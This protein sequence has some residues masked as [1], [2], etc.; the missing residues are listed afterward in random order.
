MKE[1]RCPKCAGLMVAGRVCDNTVGFWSETGQCV[2][3]SPQP[4]APKGEGKGSPMHP[5]VTY[6]C[7]NCGYL[8]WYTTSRYAI[9]TEV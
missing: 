4:I 9:K 8:E 7:G 6:R 3:D 2:L 1:K 5:I